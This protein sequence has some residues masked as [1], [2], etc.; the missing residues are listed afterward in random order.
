MTADTYRIAATDQLRTYANIL[1]APLT[2]IYSPE[3]MDQALSRLQDYDLIF[4]DT[5]GFSHKNEEQREDTK[6]LL[7]S[8]ASSYEK[9]VYLVLSATTKYRDLKDICDKYRG[10]S[11]YSIIFTKLDETSLYGNIYNIRMYSGADIAYVTNGQNVPDDME[12]FHTQEIVKK[13]LGGD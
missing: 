9:M 6:K 7:A 1:D 11:D 10:I 13:L 5:A 8:V 12:E 3:E 4:V 2:I